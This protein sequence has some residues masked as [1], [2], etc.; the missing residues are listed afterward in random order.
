MLTLFAGP[1][2]S[3]GGE[4]EKGRTLTMIAYDKQEYSTFPL[5]N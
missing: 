4:R 1:Q 2:D 5:K 3:C